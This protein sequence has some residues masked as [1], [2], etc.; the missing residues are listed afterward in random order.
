MF[1]SCHNSK[2]TTHNHKSN[3]SKHMLNFLQATQ[4]WNPWARWWKK[5]DRYTLNHGEE[6]KKS[7]LCIYQQKIEFTCKTIRCHVSYVWCP[8]L[9][10][11]LVCYV[12]CCKNYCIVWGTVCGRKFFTSCLQNIL[13][14][15]SKVSLRNAKHFASECKSFEKKKK[16]CRNSF[17]FFY[18]IWLCSITLTFHG[19]HTKLKYCYPENSKIS[20]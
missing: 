1:H 4:I 8:H 15:S 12:L 10:F 2:D 17:F 5:H 9:H 13:Q 6:I 16:N 7:V 11:L 14:E 19:L 18:P 3:G 20:K